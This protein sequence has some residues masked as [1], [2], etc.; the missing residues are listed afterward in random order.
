MAERATCELCRGP[1][2]RRGRLCDLHRLDRYGGFFRIARLYLRHGTWA[3]VGREAGLRPHEVEDAAIRVRTL[4]WR[5]LPEPLRGLPGGDPA[6]RRRHE[7]DLRAWLAAC[8]EQ[9]TDRPTWT[10]G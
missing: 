6:R 4:F 7:A 1:V 2:P 9:G 3:A 5:A 10:P 8:L